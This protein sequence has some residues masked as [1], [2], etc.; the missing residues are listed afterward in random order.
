MSDVFI[1]ASAIGNKLQVLKLY[2]KL[3]NFFCMLF[4]FHNVFLA[5]IDFGI[6]II[7]KMFYFLKP[8]FNFSLS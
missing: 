1:S 6:K 8:K 3:R 4:I 7:S 5:L 2:Y